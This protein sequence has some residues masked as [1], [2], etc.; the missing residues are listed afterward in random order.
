[1]P[2]HGQQGPQLRVPEHHRWQ[3]KVLVRIPVSENKLDSSQGMTL[4]QADLW[5]PYGWHICVSALRHTHRHEH[6]FVWCVCV[7][8]VCMVHMCIYG[9]CMMC[10]HVYVCAWWCVCV[11]CMCMCGMRVYMVYECV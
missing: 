3:I 8:Y 7:W 1:M 6:I 4:L 2:A 11:V 5:P 9:I 10:V